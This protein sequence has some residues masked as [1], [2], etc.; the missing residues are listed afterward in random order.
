MKYVL[1]PLTMILWYLTTYYGL[2][3]AVIGMAFMFS[4]SWLWLRLAGWFSWVW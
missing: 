4:L 2:Y 3:F 1:T